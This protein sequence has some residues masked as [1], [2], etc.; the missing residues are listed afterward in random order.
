MAEDCPQVSSGEALGSPTGA[1]RVSTR[2]KEGDVSTP[3]S[4]E[5]FQPYSSFCRT[6]A[7]ISRKTIWSRVRERVTLTMCASSL[8]GTLDKHHEPVDAP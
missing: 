8:L 4:G 1:S 5:K 2:G 3:L 6:R 7:R